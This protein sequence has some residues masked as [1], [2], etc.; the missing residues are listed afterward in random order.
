MHDPPHTCV[1]FPQRMSTATSCTSL[2]PQ[3]KRVTHTPC[4]RH[5]LLSPTQA[6]DPELPLTYGVPQRLLQA[7]HHPHPLSHLRP[8]SN[9]LYLATG[10]IAAGRDNPE[11][12]C[13]RV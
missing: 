1:P 5:L 4:H 13:L 10:G 3:D 8:A 11:V 2:D 9:L 12:Q 6:T 7:P